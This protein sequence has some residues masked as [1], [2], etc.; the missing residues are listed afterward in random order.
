MFQFCAVKQKQTMEKP[1]TVSKSIDIQ[2]PATRI[3]EVLTHPVY[4]SQWLSDSALEIKSDWKIGSS[5]IFSG[6]W[7]GVVFEDRGTILE[8][9][10]EKTLRYNHWTRISRLADTPENRSV[11]CFELKPAGMQTLLELTH[12]NLHAL[13]AYEHA[14]FYWNVTLELIRQ[15]AEGN[16]MVGDL[17]SHRQT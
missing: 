4:M 2:A 6:K 14:R 13:A 16:G 10:P 11:M 12:S 1:Q 7:H 3:W 9:E 17:H 5:I 15:M 8:L